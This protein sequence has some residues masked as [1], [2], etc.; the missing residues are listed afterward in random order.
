MIPRHIEA[1][2]RAAL[3]SF[4]VV[5]LLGPRQVGKTTLAPA[6]TEGWS[7]PSVYLDLERDSDRNKL[8]EPESTSVASADG[9]C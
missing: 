7:R 8:V 3:E 9:C 1:Q 6:L 5:A 2:M 4:P